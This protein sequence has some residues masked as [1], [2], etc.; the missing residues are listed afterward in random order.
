MNLNKET[1]RISEKA[2]VSVYTLLI[3]IVL[4]PINIYWNV[5]MELVRYSGLPTTISLFFNVVFNLLVLSLLNAGAKRFLKKS[6]FKPG[7]LVVIYA[8]LSIGSA[9]AGHSMMEI[10]PPMLGHPFWFATAENDWQDLFWRY[11]PRWLSIDDKNALRG[12]YEGD[13]TLYTI[14]H[15]K[16]WLT[17]VMAWSAFIF[18]VVFMMFCINIILRKQWIE[19]EKLSYPIIQLPLSM[20][21]S[22]FFSN[23]VMWLG[24]G[25]VAIVDI[26][27]GLHFLFPNVPRVFDKRYYIHFSDRPLNAMGWIPFALYPFVIG[28]GFLIPLDLSLSCWFFFWFWKTQLV[29]GNIMGLRALPGFPYLN[30]QAIGGYI[31]VAL[32]ALFVSRNHLYAALKQVFSSKGARDDSDEPMSYRTTVIAMV[33]GM[34]FLTAFCYKAGMD[35]T[36]IVIFFILYFLISLGITRMR[37]E[38][39]APVHDIHSTG[40]EVIMV[41]AVGTRQLG[42]Q[43]LTVLSFF[44]FLTRTHYSHVMPHQLEGFK[45]A[46]STRVGNQKFLLAMTLA[47]GVGILSAFWVLLH[48]PYKMGASTRIPWP[49]VTAFG[50]EPWNRLQWWL[51]SPSRSDLPSFMFMV[52]GL[53]FTFFLMFMRMK[54]FWWPLYPAAYAVTNSWGIHNIWFC[55]FLAW[56]AKQGILRY[57]GLKA[58]RQAIPFFL[59]LILG[60]FTVG[61][62]WTIIGILFGIST[63]GFYT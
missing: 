48:I 41:T 12:Y 31:G 29:L 4:I 20:T 25:I 2:S 36:V 45:L 60:E 61:S 50:R 63:Y 7:E 62:L 44:W 42:A 35:I 28:L 33:V 15:L 32:I 13:S 55:L 19:R 58:H 51:S 16:A 27:N 37:A 1:E 39:G 22:G 10:L 34:I 59:G 47:S 9:I 46:N 8:M 17:P 56:V 54:F 5:Q 26:L 14:P 3:G 57:G 6:L 53:L 49:T 52:F 30:S 23:R 40:P 11:I 43:N 21:S 24:F 18:V 38:L